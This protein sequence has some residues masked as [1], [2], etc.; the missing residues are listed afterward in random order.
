MQSQVQEKQNKMPI[1]YLWISTIS[2]HENSFNDVFH[3][4]VI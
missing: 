4:N 3:Q 2:I 1:T